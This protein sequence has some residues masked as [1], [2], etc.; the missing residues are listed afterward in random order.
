MDC[1]DLVGCAIPAA[2]YGPPSEAAGARSADRQAV[3]LGLTR[4]ADAYQPSASALQVARLVRLV[5]APYYC[6]P[7]PMA[8]SNHWSVGVTAT[9]D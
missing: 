1:A 5:T 9:H 8:V 3:L 6:T 7:V 4:N 2:P